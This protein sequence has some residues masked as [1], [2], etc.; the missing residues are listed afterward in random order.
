MCTCDYMY[1]LFLIFK[2]T[3]VSL[4]KRKKTQNAY[5][6]NHTYTRFIS[7]ANETRE[8]V[9]ICIRNLSLSLSLICIHI[10]TRHDHHIN[11]I[12]QKSGIAYSR[13]RWKWRSRSW[14]V[15]TCDN[16]RTHSLAHSHSFTLSYV[17]IH[18]HHD[19]RINC[20]SPG[21]EIAYSRRRWKQH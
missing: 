10:K 15:W 1:T 19:R 13:R 7:S 6:Y 18:T 21:S 8:R 14:N 2:S 12:T 5:T 11:C 3:H 17:H 20:I 16:I 9:I 4:D